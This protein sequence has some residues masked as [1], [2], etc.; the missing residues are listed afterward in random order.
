[1]GAEVRSLKPRSDVAA[2][3]GRYAILCS[4]RQRAVETEG[5]RRLVAPAFMQWRDCF[6]RLA[7]GGVR[8]PRPTV[9]RDSPITHAIPFTNAAMSAITSSRTW[10]GVTYSVVSR[11]PWV[12]IIR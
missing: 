7:T 6:R 4:G 12:G 10:D 5:F 3:T 9:M 8:A 11:R 2:R 1:M